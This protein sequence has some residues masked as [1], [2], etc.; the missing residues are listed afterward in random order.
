MCAQNNRFIS[1]ARCLLLRTEHAALHPLLF[2][3]FQVSQGCSHPEFPVLIHENPGVTEK[4]IQ[5]LAQ[6]T[7]R[8]GSST[9]RSLMNRRILD[10]CPTT[11]HCCLLLKI[12]LKHCYAS[13]S[14]LGRRTNSCSAG[15]TTPLT[16]ATSKCG[17]IACLSLWK[18]RL[19]VQFISGSELHRH[20]ETFCVVFYIR[21]G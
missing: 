12:L 11:S 10:L 5:N 17:T 21:E 2:P 15:F 9:T 18:R 6:V 14:R 8:T 16:G 7:S 1:L 13:R 4:L 20:R 3:L 19:D